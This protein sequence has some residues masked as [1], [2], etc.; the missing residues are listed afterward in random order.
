[1]LYS[2][3]HVYFTISNLYCFIQFYIESAQKIPKYFVF[4]CRFTTVFEKGQYHRLPLTYLLQVV[5]VNSVRFWSIHR[6]STLLHLTSSKNTDFIELTESGAAKATLMPHLYIKAV[7][8]CA[9]RHS[10]LINLGFSNEN[11]VNISS[12]FSLHSPVPGSKGVPCI[13]LV[14]RPANALGC[15][16]V[17]FHPDTAEPMLNFH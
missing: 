1:M 7:H 4:W 15:K 6:L 5:S 14:E 11:W 10:P 17:N 16:L 13:A 3:L 12:I 8:D 2:T 9:L